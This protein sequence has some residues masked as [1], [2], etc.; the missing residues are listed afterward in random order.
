LK[1]ISELI[2]ISKSEENSEYFEFDM[3]R[4]SN[5]LG[6]KIN[7]ETGMKLNLCNKI[8]SSSAISHILKRYFLKN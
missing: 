3:G 8:L 6:Q 7:Q 2:A 1:T 5:I 4:V